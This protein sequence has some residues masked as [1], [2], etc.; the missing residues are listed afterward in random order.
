MLKRSAELHRANGGHRNVYAL[1]HCT[2]QVFDVH[3]NELDFGELAHQT[4]DAA[5]EFARQRLWTAGAFRKD[6]ERVAGAQCILQRTK[7]IGVLGALAVDE[8]DIQLFHGDALAK[9]AVIP[10][11]FGSYRSRMAA[12]NAW[13]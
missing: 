13:Q 11:V 5:F 3:R 7:R 12:Q 8:H 1:G 6:D 10:I 9:Q 2:V 4:P